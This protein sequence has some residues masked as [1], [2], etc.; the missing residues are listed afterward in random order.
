MTL[1]TLREYCLSKP[2]ATEDLPFDET[3]LVF[4]VGGKIFLLTDLERTPFW[5]NLKAEP[6]KVLELC[7]RFSAITPGYH[8]NK[9]HWVTVLPD[10]TTD[11]E[12]IFGL[13]DDSY[14]L[15]LGSLNKKEKEKLKNN[16][17]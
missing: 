7:E 2:Y 11:N 14:N 13:V 10:G 17:I 6:E 4:R 9:K 12:L 8:M 15:I 5:F 16:Q 3:T 1:E